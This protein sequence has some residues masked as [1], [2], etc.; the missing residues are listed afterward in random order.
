LAL[1]EGGGSGQ[2]ER[3][4][5]PAT[6]GAGRRQRAPQRDQLTARRTISTSHGRCDVSPGWCR[7]GLGAPRWA[8]CRLLGGRSE[9]SA[10]SSP[11]RWAPARF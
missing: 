6:R 9:A 1:V 10:T 4:H 7:W 11:C 8:P 5:R 2:L 3:S